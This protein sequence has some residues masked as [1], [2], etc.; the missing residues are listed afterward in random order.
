MPVKYNCSVNRDI[1]DSSKMKVVNLPVFVLLTQC[2]N[3]LKVRVI[4]RGLLFSK[5]LENVYSIRANRNN[6]LNFTY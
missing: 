5:S 4:Q 1:T 3:E 6:I 2:L